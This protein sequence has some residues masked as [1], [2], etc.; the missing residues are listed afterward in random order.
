MS[1]SVKAGELEILIYDSGKG[2]DKTVADRLFSKGF[3]TKPSA[4]GMSLYSCRAILESHEGSVAITSEGEGK[5]AVTRI[6]FRIS[7][8]QAAA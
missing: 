7:A 1:I 3:S 5:G 8:N 4:A 2:F 6:G